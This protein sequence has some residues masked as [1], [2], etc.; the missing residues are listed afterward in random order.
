M[1][2]GP[3][4]NSIDIQT[5]SLTRRK[6]I[7]VAH[8]RCRESNVKDVITKLCHS[9]FRREYKVSSIFGGHR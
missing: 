1:E 9:L 5:L 4:D 8:L 7:D 3:V 6:A 2:N